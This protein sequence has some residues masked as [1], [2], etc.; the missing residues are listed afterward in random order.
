MAQIKANVL[1][2][3]ELPA[4]RDYVG[5]TPTVAVQSN[6]SGMSFSKFN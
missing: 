3:R 5:L 4:A 2:G 1:N 6:T